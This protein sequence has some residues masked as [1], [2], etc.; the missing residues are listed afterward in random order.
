VSGSGWTRAGRHR[1]SWIPAHPDERDHRLL[2][3]LAFG[4]CPAISMVADPAGLP[5]GV[6]KSCIVDG[7]WKV[8]GR[9]WQV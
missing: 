2:R 8:V 5:R 6:V 4:Q 3:A 9:G 1:P 7:F